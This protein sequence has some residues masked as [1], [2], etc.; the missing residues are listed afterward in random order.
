M[1]LTQK[2][3]NNQAKKGGNIKKKRCKQLFPLG[4]WRA[5]HFRENDTVQPA[6][7]HQHEGIL[8]QIHVFFNFFCLDA[9][10]VWN[11]LWHLAFSSTSLCPEEREAQVKQ[12][13]CLEVANPIAL[14]QS[15][16]LCAERNRTAG[17]PNATRDHKT[18]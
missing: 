3:L 13:L 11:Q 6:L 14:S 1:H 16:D 7:T 18:K 10:L 17:A 15:K 4:T 8:H 9:F 12:Q 2:K 5:A